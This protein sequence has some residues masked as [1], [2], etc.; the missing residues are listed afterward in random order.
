MNLAATWNVTFYFLSSI[1]FTVLLKK[2]TYLQCC[3][4]KYIEFGPDPESWPNLDPGPVR[5]NV[6]NYK[7]KKFENIF[8]AQQFSLKSFK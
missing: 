4:S 5:G 1:A 2:F 7:E 6:I 3:G 8:V